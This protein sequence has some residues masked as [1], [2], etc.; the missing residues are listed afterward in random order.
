MFIQLSLNSHHLTLK[1]KRTYLNF[2]VLHSLFS[3]CIV[4]FQFLNRLISFTE[5]LSIC[6]FSSFCRGHFS[7]M[8]IS[9]IHQFLE[10]LLSNT[11]LPILLS[12][13]SYFL[14]SSMLTFRVLCQ[15]EYLLCEFFN[16]LIKSGILMLF[17]MQNDVFMDQ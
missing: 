12:C 2:S 13:P 15:I 6:S 10:D 4:F 14:K 16:H 7:T 9:G 8:Y 11:H 5:F 3:E 1:A 17:R